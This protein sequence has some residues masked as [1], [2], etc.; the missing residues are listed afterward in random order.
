MDLGAAFRNYVF[1]HQSKSSLPTVPYPFIASCKWWKTQGMLE[2]KPKITK[3]YFPKKDAT[4]IA[5][6]HENHK[7]YFSREPIFT[8]FEI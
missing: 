6:L 8:P 5:I 4:V 7:K 1:P 3:K 2:I